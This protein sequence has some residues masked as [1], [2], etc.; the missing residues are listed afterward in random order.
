MAVFGLL[1]WKVLR[2][3]SLQVIQSFLVQ[4]TKGRI[5]GRPFPFKEPRRLA[6]NLFDPIQPRRQ[7]VLGPNRD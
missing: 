7:I 3:N 2:R 6:S 1:N 4:L 5:Y